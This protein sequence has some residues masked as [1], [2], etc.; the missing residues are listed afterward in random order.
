MLSGE[1]TGAVSLA[2]KSCSD[3][4]MLREIVQ[5]YVNGKHSGLGHGSH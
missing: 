1:E 4:I 2:M 3:V 5:I